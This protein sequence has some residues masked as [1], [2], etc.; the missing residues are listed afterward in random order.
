MA[1]P[2][3]CGILIKTYNARSSASR[4]S[5]TAPD[6]NVT[7]TSFFENNLQG[8]TPSRLRPRTLNH[9]HRPREGLLQPPPPSSAPPSRKAFQLEHPRHYEL[10]E[11]SYPNR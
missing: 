3:L 5:E 11:L 10:H 7:A 2:S 8:R 9:L 4:N 1:D 6:S